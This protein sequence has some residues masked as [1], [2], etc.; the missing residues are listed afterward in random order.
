ALFAPERKALFTSDTVLAVSTTSI[1]PHDGNLADY[2]RTLEMLKDVDARVMYTGHGGPVKRPKARL[3]ALIKHRHEREQAIL[4][5]LREGPLT[6]AELR[7][8]I[9]TRLPQSRERLAER[10]LVT[11][12]TKL[13]EEQAVVAEENDRYALR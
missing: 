8:R 12:L 13:I 11:T 7:V 6:P 5:A 10:Q 2:M 9:Y 4:N 3:N 1:G